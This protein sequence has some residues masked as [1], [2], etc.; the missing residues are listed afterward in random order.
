MRRICALVLLLAFAPTAR[1]QQRPLE[2]RDLPRRVEARLRTLL[3]DSATLQ[4]NGPTRIAA[5]RTIRGNVTA[6]GGPFTIAGTVV[7]DLVVVDGDLVFEPG[8]EVGGDVTVVAGRTRGVG[9]ATIAG[10]LTVY[11]EGF[12]AGVGGSRV[13]GSDERGDDDWAWWWGEEDRR[14]RDRG[15]SRI[16][17]RP[18]GAYNRVEGLPIQI[19]PLVQTDG[20]NPL[21]LTALAIVRTENGG[22]FDR[23]DLGYSLRAE[24]F[25]GGGGELSVGLAAHSIVQPIDAWSLGGLEAS[26][27]TFLLHSDPRDYYDRTGWSAFARY[28]PLWLPLDATLGFRSDDY[29]IA[30]VNDPYTLFGDDPWRPQPLAA[31]G[32]LHSITGSVELDARDDDDFPTRGWYVRATALR[33][34]EGSIEV[35]GFAG[36]QPIPDVIPV[37]GPQRFE[38]GG[39]TH[40]LFDGRRYTRVGG[41]GLLAFRLVAGGTPADQSL[42]PQFQH[43]LGGA[44]TAPGFARLA[45]DCGA[46]RARVLPTVGGS[47]YPFYGCDRFALFQAEY[48]GEIDVGLD[49]DDEDDFEDADDWWD[50]A[51]NWDLDLDPAWAVFFDAAQGWTLRETSGTIEAVDTGMNYDIGAGLLLGDFGVYGALPLTGPDEDLRIVVRLGRRF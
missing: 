29:G 48:I 6:F 28:T 3:D 8:G 23:D 40:L 7:G 34:I 50:Y 11:G 45:L 18:G 51:W 21:R 26:L 17:V 37:I 31:T 35:P 47:F 1:A 41:D 39:I 2:D 19:G 49:F 25:L 32:T 43:V 16:V 30:P 27:S 13:A 33:G 38:A 9:S 46:R 12:G 44:G 15:Y 36:P 5:G 22:D 20:P 10:T 24:Q 4:F 42:P 14:V